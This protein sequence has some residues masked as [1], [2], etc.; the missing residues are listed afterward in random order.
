MQRGLTNCLLYDATDAMASI[1]VYLLDIILIPLSTTSDAS[2]RKHALRCAFLVCRKLF[3]A[4]TGLE[5]YSD[6]VMPHFDT[7]DN[8]RTKNVDQ[9]SLWQVHNHVR[10]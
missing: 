4:G 1:V 2:A 10:L 6:V 9:G 7:I 8:F 3:Q 5:A